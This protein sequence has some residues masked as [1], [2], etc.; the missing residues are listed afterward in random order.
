MRLGA[1]CEERI[2]CIHFPEIIWSVMNF[3]TDN[4][5]Q[6]RIKQENIMDFALP[7]QVKLRNFFVKIILLD[8]R[9]KRL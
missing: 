2:P 1:S 4:I 7:S 9:S 3:L 5:E 8:M 6:L